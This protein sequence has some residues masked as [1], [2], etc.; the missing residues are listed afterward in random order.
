MSIQL[1]RE[2]N[3]LQHRALDASGIK[4]VQDTLKLDHWSIAFLGEGFIWLDKTFNVF[5]AALDE[6]ADE[7]TSRGP[8]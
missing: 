8:F 4:K 6:I 3:E 5:A 2:V 1:F 7:H